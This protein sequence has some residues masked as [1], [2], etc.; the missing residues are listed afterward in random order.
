M[1]K[2]RTGREVKKTGL[3][4]DAETLPHKLTFRHNDETQ[5]MID[6]V[7]RAGFF[8]SPSDLARRVIELFGNVLLAEVDRSG[9]TPRRIADE[10]IESAMS[11]LVRELARK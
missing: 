4:P 5:A 1:P 8:S 11:R 10:M 6:R 7:V 9:K 3:E 2:R